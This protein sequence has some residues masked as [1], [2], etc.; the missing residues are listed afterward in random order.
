[1]NFRLLVAAVT[2]STCSFGAFSVNIAN[3]ATFTFDAGIA[4]SSADLINGVTLAGSTWN[5]AGTATWTSDLNFIYM[6]FA[7][8]ETFIGAQIWGDSDDVYMLQAW[9]GG[10]WQQMWPVPHELS[11]VPSEIHG[12]ASGQVGAAYYGAGLTSQTTDKL[13][14][15]RAPDAPND[16]QYSLSEIELYVAGVPEP[17]TFALLGIGLGVLALRRR[18]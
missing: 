14:I 17:S 15:G 7:A 18:K 4:G 12:R 5:A 13:R 9:V 3:Q 10:S 8:P 2:F 6:D 1:M 16:F 11:F